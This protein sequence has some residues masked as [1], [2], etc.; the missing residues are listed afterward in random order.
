VRHLDRLA[1]LE[2]R[3]LGKNVIFI[4]D[5]LVADRDCAKVDALLRVDP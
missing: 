2:L 1:F 4:D 5:N 3:V